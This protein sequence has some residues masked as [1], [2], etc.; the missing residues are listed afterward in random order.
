MGKLN[1]EGQELRDYIELSASIMEPCI[2]DVFINKR[3]L[4][5]VGMPAERVD[6]FI[7]EMIRQHDSFYQGLDEDEY[8][9][10]MIREKEKVLEQL[11]LPR[12]E[13]IGHI[14]EK[15]DLADLCRE[16]MNHMERNI[17]QVMFMKRGMEIMGVDP[18]SIACA[19]M[20][21]AREYDEKYSGMPDDEFD[22]ALFDRML[23][24]LLGEPVDEEIDPETAA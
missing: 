22:K 2:E 11:S 1:M 4:M 24:R 3:L 16:N 21:S 23:E 17:R 12:E 7:E 10:Y 5:D 13:R 18:Y 9:E 8:N 15:P 14:P 19:I 6:D 20:D